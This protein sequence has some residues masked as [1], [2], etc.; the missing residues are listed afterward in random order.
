[1]P[2][3]QDDSKTDPNRRTSNRRGGLSVGWAILM[4]DGPVE[5]P[6]WVIDESPTGVGLETRK[7]FSPCP[8]ER[9]QTYWMRLK[10][11]SAR[12]DHWVAATIK[13]IRE[14]GVGSGIYKL[15][16]HIATTPPPELGHA[17]SL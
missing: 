7:Q 9:N 6:C 15:G 4:L 3:K 12:H 8:V 10:P 5:V 17:P 1:M 13:H 2:G 11:S 14:K 16:V